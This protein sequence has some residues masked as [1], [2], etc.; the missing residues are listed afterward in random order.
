MMTIQMAKSCCVGAVFECMHIMS[1]VLKKKTD[2][3][4][5]NV[6]DYMR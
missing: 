3:Y 6:V 5:T 2:V 4:Y 1:A